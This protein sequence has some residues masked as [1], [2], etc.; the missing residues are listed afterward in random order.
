M[1]HLDSLPQFIEVLNFVAATVCLLYIRRLGSFKVDIV[2]IFIVQILTLNELQI[3]MLFS[4]NC[5]ELDQARLA[6]AQIILA[7]HIILTF[8]LPL[9]CIL[10]HQTCV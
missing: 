9:E 1:L 8:P 3:S 5:L 6:L 7:L 2:V 4:P 10:H